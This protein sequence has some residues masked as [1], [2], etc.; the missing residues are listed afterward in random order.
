MGSGSSRNGGLRG[1]PHE[2][3]R[4]P[5]APALLAPASTHTYG[6]MGYPGIC[7]QRR[8][9]ADQVY[10]SV[11]EESHH[12]LLAWKPRLH[13]GHLVLLLLLKQAKNRSLC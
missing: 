6:L 2:G 10:V 13:P 5:T 9:S 4:T 1:T 8:E 7:L 3:A 11:R 12:T